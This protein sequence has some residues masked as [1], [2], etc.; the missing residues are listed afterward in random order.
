MQKWILTI[1]SPEH[2]VLSQPPTRRRKNGQRNTPK[3]YRGS[4]QERLLEV[5]Q[6]ECQ[7]SGIGTDSDAE[8]KAVDRPFPQEHRNR[9]R[10]E[11]AK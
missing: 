7:T 10:T 3:D 6:N 2:L 1:F 9:G 8:K 11:E 5:D 4:P